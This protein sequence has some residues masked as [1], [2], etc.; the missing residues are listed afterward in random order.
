MRAKIIAER[1]M[2]I[3][4]KVSILYRIF[5]EVFSEEREFWI[6]LSNEEI[7]HKGFIEKHLNEIE[8][9]K[10]DEIGM[11]ETELTETEEFIDAV[12][13]KYSIGNHDKLEAYEDAFKIES[14]ALERHI[15]RQQHGESANDGECFNGLQLRDVEHLSK[16]MK[17]MKNAYLNKGSNYDT[18][19]R[20]S[21]K[22]EIAARNIYLYFASR[23]F[24]HKEAAIFFN[25]MAEQEKMH[26]DE[27]LRIYEN[28]GR[29]KLTEKYVELY[30]AMDS[31]IMLVDVL[32]N[33]V[34]NVT[35]I[36]D[37]LRIAH[38]VENSEINIIFSGIVEK[39]MNSEEKKN[40]IL[41]Q[42]NQH[43]TSL[44]LFSKNYK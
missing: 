5:S 6:E 44:I 40:F 13:K 22:H 19:F 29:E 30:R 2:N 3:E 1:M 38:Q 37:A 26:H 12:I 9:L 32:H 24:S 28:I 20:V 8:M 15:S 35:S 14:T 4:I 36:K 31:Y 33:Q 42:L 25:N 7:E 18:L 23:F 27:L 11:L 17:I 43:N 21:L 39:F 34:K 16:I 41:M 10:M